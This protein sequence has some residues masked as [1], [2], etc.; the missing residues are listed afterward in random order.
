[1]KYLLIS[2]MLLV[3]CTTPR[4]SFSQGLH[5]A[6]NKAVRAYN[7]G[8]SYYD[9]IDYPNAELQF[10]E[11]LKI[12]NKFFEAYMMLGELY[13]RQKKYTDA[14][15]SY[16]TALKID[17]L[18]YKP[19]YFSLATAEFMT[20]DYDGALK[21]Y[22]AYLRH[23]G[24]SEKN[25][26]IAEKNIRNC[27]FAIEAIKK[28]VLFNP[29]SVGNG[30][31]TADDEY[32]PSITADGQTLMF[33]RQERTYYTGKM[34][35]FQEDFYISF[36]TDA[37]WGKAVNA[38]EPLNTS[39]N[40]GAQTLSSSGNYMYFT[41]CERSGGL[42]SCDLY[43][44]AFNNNRW[45]LPHNLGWPVNTTSWESTPSI[46]ADGDM[47]FFSSSRPGGI[48]G[49]DLWVSFMTPK[50]TW[51]NPV[52]LGKVVN[53]PG[54]EMSPF[55]HFDGRTLYFAS[56][57]RPGMGGL[58]IFMTKM[59]DDTTWTEPQNLGYPVN[60]SSD[61]MGLVIDASGQKAYFSSKRDNQNGKDIFS[62]N[63]DESMRPNPVSYL[64][65]KVTDK[66]TGQLLK[67]NY[68][69]I[70]LTTGKATI[71]SST[72]DQ[73]NF[74]VCL[75]SGFN[76][77]INV[78]K[79]GY[80]FYSENF[81]FE[82][83][84]TV[85]EPLIKKISLSP[86]KVGER[87]LLSNV[88]YEV[89]SWKLKKESVQELDNLADLLNDNKDI[90]VEIGGYTDSTGTAEY[91]LVLSEKRALSV[92]NYLIAKGISSERLK[93]KGYGNTS[94]IGDNVT[95]EGR[96]LNRRTEVKVVAGKK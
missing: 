61:D 68:E 15:A 80:L 88:F 25:K 24:S 92:V 95:I 51:A 73:G 40:E 9:Y 35:S 81:M 77:G 50:G 59:K 43:F 96:K 86:A 2:I 39:N 82:G 6:S 14:A 67:A 46:S 49:K 78:S 62:F 29:V 90:T 19:G 83:Q 69:L 74:L 23:S 94:P 52:N 65:G 84:H 16:Q 33:T 89:D 32:W 36:M 87:M 63:L 57:G 64:K 38:G 20:G 8:M 70:N 1:M 13:T 3:S 56:D 60:T 41:A 10:R 21:H 79:T 47:L 22:R 7:E 72:D 48:G 4:K 71:K 5:T 85:M 66:E 28:P 17:S 91:N 75:P 26:P 30:I 58:D 53:T 12:D 31:N 76:Y 44:S 34:S 27:L 42:G 55:I 45:T 93:F 18:A 37:G 11:A 54:D